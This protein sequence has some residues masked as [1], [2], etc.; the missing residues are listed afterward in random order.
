MENTPSRLP[1]PCPWRYWCCAACGHEELEAHREGRTV[2]L[3]GII[4]AEPCQC[5]APM[6]LCS[7]RIGADARRS[8]PDDPRE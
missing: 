7:D 1:H 5:G 6:R 8:P 4:R 2:S 3:D